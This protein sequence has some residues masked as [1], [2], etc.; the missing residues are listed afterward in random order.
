MAQIRSHPQP[1]DE[2]AAE[3]RFL[4]LLEE[5]GLLETRGLSSRERRE[6]PLPLPAKVPGPC[7]S[8]III[9][10]RR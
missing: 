5:K 3:E 6:H 8:E 2:R 4:D 10:D 7:A 9:R 1:E